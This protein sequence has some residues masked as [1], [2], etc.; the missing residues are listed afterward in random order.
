MLQ[1]VHDMTDAEIIEKT[2]VD[3]AFFGQI[4]VRYE[5]KLLRYIQRLGVYSREDC[6]DV[7][8]EVFIKVYR[9]LH[10]FDATFSFSSWI[11][12]IAHNEAISLYRKKHA[13]PEG[14]LIDEGDERVFREIAGGDD[15]ETLY[16]TELNAQRVQAALA[17]LEDKYRDVLILRFFEHMEYEDISDVLKIPIGSVGTLIHRGK[18]RLQNILNT[19]QLRV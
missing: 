1:N 2:L 17:K 15:V 10:A 13:R 14:H 12:R 19:E 3:Q 6:Q 7:L 11:Y 4:V 5:G 9:N 8:Q 18:K 16:D